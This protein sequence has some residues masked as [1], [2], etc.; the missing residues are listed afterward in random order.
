MNGRPERLLVAKTKHNHAP[1]TQEPQ[2]KAS[3]VP[4]RTDTNVLIWCLRALQYCQLTNTLNRVSKDFSSMDDLLDACSSFSEFKKVKKLAKLVQHI[5]ATLDQL[6]SIEH[7]PSAVELSIETISKHCSITHAE[8]QTF[9][10]AMIIH[11][12]ELL[13]DVFDRCFKKVNNSRLCKILAYVLNEPEGDIK[14]VFHPKG[15]LN[16]AGMLSFDFSSGFGVQSHLDLGCG[17]RETLEIANGDWITIVDGVCNQAKT[18][19]LIESDFS[20]VSKE[21]SLVLNYIKGAAG[22]NRIGANVLIYGPPGCGKTEFSRAV[23]AASGLRGFE[24][25]SEKADGSSTTSATRRSYFRQANIYLQNDPSSILLI[26]EMDGMMEIDDEM[27]RRD[28]GNNFSKASANAQLESNQIPSIW[29]TN[30]SCQFDPAQLRRF[31]LVIQFNPPSHK[32]IKLQLADKLATHGI[33]DTWLDAASR[34][35][36][37]TPGLVNTLSL[38][39][40]SVEHGSEGSKT[41]NMEELLN[42]ALRQRGIKIAYT[43]TQKYR[44]EY[45][46]SSI[47]VT[48]LTSTL[49]AKKDARCLLHGSTGTGKTAFARHMSETLNL[50][51]KLVRPSDILDM[52]VGGTERNIARLFETTNPEDTLIIL[53]EFESLAA[54]RRGSTHNWEVSQINEMLTQIEAYQGKIIACT[55][56]VDHIDPAIRRRF[57]LKVELLPLNQ[58]QRINLFKECCKKL[59]LDSE[60]ST[61]AISQ[62]HST[63]QLA[64][65][66]FANAVEIAEY[67]P[68]LT[69]N[70][71]VESLMQELESTN[72]TIARNIGFT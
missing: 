1:V 26:D 19:T 45:C 44:I 72:G 6:Q 54:D 52:Y 12:N 28:F 60:F 21:W 39:A 16:R 53:D 10:F 4:S 55:N 64:Y 42:T 24:L 51:P 31:D 66:H 22:N 40:D 47:P 14:A 69:V 13:E 23:L 33:A 41:P 5:P 49:T 2:F 70:T 29:I 50:E 15:F 9:L 43:K 65:G 63:E 67:V 37:L 3:A 61:S 62:L 57:Q 27:G 20:H 32:A 58:Q 68:D 8:Q 36:G 46:N 34:T 11:E 71:F 18:T 7:T 38:V 56:L 59:K 30:D 25:L 17:V 35:S 48:T